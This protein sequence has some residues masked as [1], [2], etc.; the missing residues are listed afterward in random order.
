MHRLLLPPRRQ[1]L[2]RQR[3]VPNRQVARAIE[4]GKLLERNGIQAFAAQNGI[5]PSPYS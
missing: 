4:Y 1:I 3:K 2:D 5:H